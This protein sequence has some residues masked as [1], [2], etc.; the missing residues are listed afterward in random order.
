MT[1]KK[2]R[3]SIHKDYSQSRRW[4]EGERWRDSDGE[5]N[6]KQ[7][8]HS[9]SQS[10]EESDMMKDDKLDILIGKGR[11]PQ[12]FFQLAEVSIDSIPLKSIITKNITEADKGSMANN[13]PDSKLYEYYEAKYPNEFEEIARNTTQSIENV[14]KG[15]AEHTGYGKVASSEI[16]GEE[17]FSKF[18]LSLL[19]H[20]FEAFDE[21]FDQFNFF[22]DNPEMLFRAQHELNL[23]SEQNEENKYK[24]PKS[25]K[26]PDNDLYTPGS[27]MRYDDLLN[28]QSPLSKMETTHKPQQV[29]K[30]NPD[31]TTSNFKPIITTKPNARMSLEESMKRKQPRTHVDNYPFR[32]DYYTNGIGGNVTKESAPHPYYEEL[33]QFEPK[34]NHC[35]PPTKLK[36]PEGLDVVNCTWID[37][38]EELNMLANML[39]GEPIFAIDLEHHNYRSYLGITCLMQIST[40]KEDYLID[41]LALHE[42][43]QR[44]NTSF[45]NENIIKVMHGA[46]NDILWMQRDLGLYIVNM[47][48]TGQASRSLGLKHLSLS[49]LLET[50]IG[51]DVDKSNQLADWRVRPLPYKMIQ[52]ARQDTHYL[53]H[54]FERQLV[55]LKQKSP[56]GRLI[57]EVYKNSKFICMRRYEK[58][59]FNDTIFV[60]VAERNKFTHQLERELL[61]QLYRWR[62]TI[63]RKHDES[64]RYVSENFILTNICCT[65]PTTVPD[66]LKMPVMLPFLVK[67]YAADIINMVNE[68]MDLYSDKMNDDDVKPFV[69]TPRKP[70][71]EQVSHQ[72]L[73]DLLDQ[74]GWVAEKVPACTYPDI[75]KGLFQFVPSRNHVKIQHRPQFSMPMIYPSTTSLPFQQ[76][77]QP[78]PVLLMDPLNI[79][80]LRSHVDIV[81]NVPLESPESPS[82][83][84]PVN[85]QAIHKQSSEEKRKFRAQKKKKKT[86]ATTRDVNDSAVFPD[87]ELMM[88]EKAYLQSIGWTIESN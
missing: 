52:Y 33:Q 84:I 29:Y 59:E 67:Y 56:D 27:K 12:D 15:I 49:Y 23:P 88:S 55:A 20:E 30:I 38:S 44:L 24:T 8:S 41:T 51:C 63:A 77:F 87:S 72:N 14:L 1:S 39:D 36:M 70:K 82:K 45:T 79:D 46:D 17:N 13:L 85:E 6:N 69:G 3:R 34:D 68:C 71:E 57:K 43:I 32:R 10:K 64:P 74:L 48:D 2:R 25:N 73:N 4:R 81:K 50:Y 7:R 58:Y 19:Q 61:K 60:D 42:D 35:T 22:S 37:N 16:N 21:A 5:S 66:L 75:E 54:L 11:D 62:D 28:K 65:K 40:R 53:I 9:R 31:N 18:I 80:S 47:W 86:R 83:D 78:P 76:P 26:Y